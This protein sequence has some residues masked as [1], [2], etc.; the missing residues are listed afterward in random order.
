MD[1]I[2][3]TKTVLYMEVSL[4]QRLIITVKFYCGIR[5]SGLNREMYFIQS[6]L[7]REVPLYTIQP[8]HPPEI[9]SLG[10]GGMN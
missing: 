3:A 1:T 8:A 7:V 10:N 6:V 2:G 4:I 9:S 5:T